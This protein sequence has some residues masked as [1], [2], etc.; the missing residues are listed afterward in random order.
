MTYEGCLTSSE[1][2]APSTVSMIGK[3]DAY[4]NWN[5]IYF[6]FGANNP[7]FVPTGNC[8]QSRN[9]SSNGN[10]FLI[11]FSQ[12][13]DLSTSCPG[14]QIEA[15]CGFSMLRMQRS[16]GMHYEFTPFYVGTTASGGFSVDG[17]IWQHA[18][19]VPSRCEAYEKQCVVQAI[20]QIYAMGEGEACNPCEH[21]KSNSP[22]NCKKE[23]KK[24]L[25]EILSLSV[26]NTL[27]VF[28]L[29]VAV[30]PMFLAKPP[31][32]EQDLDVEETSK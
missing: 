5:Y 13:F 26:S 30:A 11:N 29:L 28:S 2:S 12:N 25:L 6:P 24:K 10:G 31:S 9:V 17:A 19:D 4:G 32:A 1:Y 16:T 20:N 14:I 18:K 15:S 7:D 21:F 27:A 3:E 8:A 23:Q 22:F